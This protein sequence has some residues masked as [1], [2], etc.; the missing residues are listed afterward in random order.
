MSKKKPVFE[1]M[2]EKKVITD[3]TRTIELYHVTGSMHNDGMI[4]AWL[5][6]ERIL[7]EADEFN[8]PPTR[9]TATPNPIHP[10]HPHFAELLDSL[11]IDPQTIVPIHLP[12]DRRT[13][14]KAELLLMAG[15]PAQV[16]QVR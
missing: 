7:V 1:T 13:V 10:Y 8:V 9:L 15:K 11:K 5:P 16:A 14:T 6:K 3:G 4:M 12:A 2:T